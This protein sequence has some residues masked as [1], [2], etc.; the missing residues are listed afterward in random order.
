MKKCPKC[1]RIYVDNSFSFCLEDGAILLT[2]KESEQSTIVLGRQANGKTH[3]N[4]WKD[5]KVHFEISV[6]PDY[7]KGYFGIFPEEIVIDYKVGSETSLFL[8]EEKVFAETLVQQKILKRLY[9]KCGVVKTQFGIV[10]FVLFYFLD[11][12]NSKPY[13]S[14][15]ENF[16]NFTEPQHLKT[17]WNLARQTHW[18]L[19]LL[20]DEELVVDLYEYTNVFDLERVLDFAKTIEKRISKEQFDLVLEELTG[21]YSTDDLFN[22]D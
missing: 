3:F 5:G 13:W 8:I 17:Y 16:I 7:L 21:K 14:I 11:P 2:E 6:I 10:G 22:L 4:Q 18:H 20:N 12:F 9:T 19:V 15:Y 1:E